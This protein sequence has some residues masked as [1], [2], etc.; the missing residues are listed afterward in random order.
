MLGFFRQVT[1]LAAACKGSH[2]CRHQRF[3][4]EFQAAGAPEAGDLM[5]GFL[6]AGFS[7]ASNTSLSWQAPP[8]FGR[9]ASIFA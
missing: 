5:Q 6:F 4:M 8:V 7:F 1:P 9:Q 3:E 2:S